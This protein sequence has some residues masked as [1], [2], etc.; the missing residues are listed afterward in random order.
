MLRLGRYL[1]MVVLLLVVCGLPSRNWAQEKRTPVMVEVKRRPIMIEGKTFLPLRVLA[2]PFSNIYKEPETAK[3]T[4][5]E[6]VP[7]FQAYYVYTRP[8]VKAT[9]TETT[10]W[11]EVGSDNRGTVLGWMRAE[12]VLEWKQN[13][14][15]AYTHPEGRKPVLLFEK[16]EAVLD[17]VKAPSD[18]RKQRAEALYAAIQAK[19]IPADFPVRSVEP[20]GYIDISSQF[21]LLPIL[22][23]GEA[24]LDQYETRILKLAAAVL[25]GGDAREQ[26]TLTG[27]TNYL[28]QAVS[29][30]P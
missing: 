13:M 17:L 5:E 12:D 18:Q 3:G 2:R 19:K 6:N 16:R 4:V 9:G 14:S 25:Q 30:K 27:N 10:G 29:R 8:E 15:L 7:T 26:S 1:T 22:E 20:N 28:D 11:Y 23:F 21:Y 24:G